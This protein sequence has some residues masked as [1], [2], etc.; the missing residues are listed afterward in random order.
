MLYF[1]LLD[2]MV[3]TEFAAPDESVQPEHALVFLPVE[4]AKFLDENFDEIFKEIV[5]LDKIKLGMV[6]ERYKFILRDAM[7][8][9]FMVLK[10]LKQQRNNG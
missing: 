4:H 9:F 7:L 5:P 8:L 6:L 3:G 2:L 1:T 10:Q